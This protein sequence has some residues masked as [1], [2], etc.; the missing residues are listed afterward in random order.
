LAVK[1]ADSKL[2]S[3]EGR[4]TGGIGAIDQLTVAVEAGAVQ[5]VGP[6]AVRA[7]HHHRGRLA[8]ISALAVRPHQ[9]ARAKVVYS[10]GDPDS[11]AVGLV[12]VES[13]GLGAVLY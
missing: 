7:E 3:T 6:G 11:Q 1:A 13:V 5:L 4:K 8:G 9:I 12:M 2:G 10:V